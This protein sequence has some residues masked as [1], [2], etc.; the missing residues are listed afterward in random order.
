[1]SRAHT[2]KVPRGMGSGIDVGDEVNEVENERSLE[3][4]REREM[5]E[6][7]WWKRPLKNSRGDLKTIKPSLL[8]LRTTFP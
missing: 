3:M 8:L 7:G 4:R 1:M 6:G 5:E 2:G